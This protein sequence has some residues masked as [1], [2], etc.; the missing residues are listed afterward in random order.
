L[1]LINIDIKRIYQYALG[2]VRES[3]AS[4]LAN[5]GN[6]LTV[7]QET[8]GAFIN[9]NVNNALVAA[10]TPKGGLPER[11]AVTPRGKLCMRYDPDTR[12]LAI[13]VAELRKYFTS[14]QVD[15]RDSLAKL[16]EAKYVKHGGKSHPT[17]IG[18]GAVGGLSGIAVRCYIFDGDAI[19]IDETAFPQADDTSTI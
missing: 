5:V 12:T 13:P 15:V 18:A 9:E 1:G 19:G 6:P 3:I 7:A 17:R 2:V 11:P 14:R 10:Y 8:L 4:N 16:T